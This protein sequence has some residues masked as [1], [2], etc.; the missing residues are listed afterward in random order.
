MSDI[1]RSSEEP[2]VAPSLG[3]GSWEKVNS[4]ALWVHAQTDVTT[5]QHGSLSSGLSSLIPHRCSMF[6]LVRLQPDGTGRYVHPVSATMSQQAL[7][8]YYRR[9]SALDYTVWSFDQTTVNVYRDLDLV[10]VA[11]RDGTPIYREWMQPQGI[12]FGCSATLA[13][14]GTSLGSVTLFREREGGDFT[15]TQMRILLEVARHLSVRL[16]TL[17]PRGINSDVVLPGEDQA[18][19]VAACYGLS[20]REEQVLR[21]ML[22]GKTNRLVAEALYVSESTVKKHVN[23][24]YHKLG[25][26]NRMQ[27]AHLLLTT[28]EDKNSVEIPYNVSP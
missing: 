26:D 16:G 7:E 1:N 18:S 6:D 17:F 11:R 25:V 10:D 8:A 21:L 13:Y 15:P 3:A 22:T 24:I 20:E 4:L 14:K 2:T 27:L 28:P 9:Y 19:V 5:L 23:A 12:Y